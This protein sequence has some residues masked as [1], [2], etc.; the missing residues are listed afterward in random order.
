MI[1]EENFLSAV[2]QLLYTRGQWKGWL[3]DIGQGNTTAKISKRDMLE[4]LP[5]VVISGMQKVLN[6]MIF[7][8][9]LF[10]ND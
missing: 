6:V 4:M 1:Y 7:Y 9:F 2:F 8:H 10:Y 5:L 3:Q